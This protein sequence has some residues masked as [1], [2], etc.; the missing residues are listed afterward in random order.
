MKQPRLRLYLDGA[1]KF[2]DQMYPRVIRVMDMYDVF[3]RIEP[4]LPTV[5]SLQKILKE[6]ETNRQAVMQQCMDFRNQVEAV[7][8]KSKAEVVDM[9]IRYFA[10]CDWVEQDL[11]ISQRIHMAINEADHFTKVLD[12]TLFYRHVDHIMGHIPPEYSSC[13]EKIT[14]TPMPKPTDDIS[15]N[16][17]DVGSIAAGAAKCMFDE[18]TWIWVHIVAHNYAVFQSNQVYTPHWIVGGC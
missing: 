12:W 5:E 3:W 9:D 18:D 6:D 14:R 2:T 7:I 16:D 11:I 4:T 15:I 8:A 13:Y 10:L 17:M 1:E